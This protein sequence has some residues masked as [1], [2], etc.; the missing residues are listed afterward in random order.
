MSALVDCPHCST[1]VLPMPGR[2]C[3][4][5]RKNVDAAPDHEPTP[6]RVAEAAYGF[7]A[8]QIGS[9]VTP[10]EVRKDLTARGLDA[11]SAAT[12]VGNLERIKAD[13][14]R[15]AG[16][17]NMLYGALWCVGGLGVTAYTYQMAASGGGGKYIVAWGA[18][19]FGA[20]Q[21]LRGLSQSAGE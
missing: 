7:A 2:V 18:I 14:I 8:Q 15:V 12:V 13:A 1:R 5:C 3:P 9:G 17:K 10:S 16:R 20:V 4:A 19:L 11:E 21:F 6:E